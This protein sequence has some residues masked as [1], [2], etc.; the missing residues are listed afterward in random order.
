MADYTIRD[1]KDRKRGGPW[2]TE[3][4]AR[5]AAAAVASTDYTLQGGYTAD[6]RHRCAIHVMR[7]GVKVATIRP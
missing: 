4:A 6:D 3:W 1:Q 2:T 5:D 7:D